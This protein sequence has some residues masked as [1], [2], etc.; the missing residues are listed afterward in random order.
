[1]RWIAFPLHPETPEQGQSLASLFAGRDIDIPSVLAHLK[2]TA[3]KLGLAFNERNMTYNS[4][5]AQEMAKYAEAQGCGHEF[6]R[7]VFE[8][9]FARG[10]NIVN[11]DVLGKIAAAAGLDPLGA[12]QAVRQGRYTEAVD[13]EW[14]RCRDMRITAVPTFHI[15][16]RRLVGA[17]SYEAIAAMVRAAGVA[18]RA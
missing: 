14:Q 2:A 3:E 4:R 6:H 16:G 8:A 17:Q 1:M 18:E 9:Y 10:E 13:Q 7:R 12:E 15:D 5:R 11:Y